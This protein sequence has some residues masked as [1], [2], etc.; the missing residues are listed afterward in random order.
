[1]KSIIIAPRRYVQG[2]NVL[3][4]AGTYLAMLGN[5]ALVLWDPVVKGLIG[6]TLL[7][8][9][10][11]AGVEA[12]PVDFNGETTHDEAKRVAAIA[13]E[14]G[15]DAIIGCG[16][17]KTLDTGKG[18]AV[19]IGAKIVTIPTIASNDS[20]TS[21]ASVWYDETHMFLGFDY[22]EKTDDEAE[23]YRFLWRL[24]R[25]EN[26]PKEGK[27]LDLLFIPIIRSEPDGETDE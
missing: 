10:A 22:D 13:K 12:V 7:A 19:E 2:K 26:G 21:A 15:V 6:E 24:F 18:A 16:G 9:M 5:K 3:A 1:M 25:Y 17:G 14:A 27:K 23:R 20:P 4:E 11:E 8:S